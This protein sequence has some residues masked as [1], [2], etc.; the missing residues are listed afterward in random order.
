[1]LLLRGPS[2]A[3]GSKHAGRGDA[4]NELSTKRPLLEPSEAAPIV[5]ELIEGPPLARPPTVPHKVGNLPL[6]VAQSTIDGE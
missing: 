1:M 5:N 6:P 3:V 2:H 4:F